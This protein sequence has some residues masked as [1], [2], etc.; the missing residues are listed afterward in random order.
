MKKIYLD[1]A[2]STP[3]SWRAFVAG[4]GYSL[5]HFGN[6]LSA[7]G[8]GKKAFKVIDQSRQ[9][10]AS[11]IK[12]NKSEI[13]FCGSGTESINLALIGSARANWGRGKHIITSA[14]EHH[15]VLNSLEYLESH[16]FEV[17]YLPVNELGL[18][19]LNDVKKFM[20]SDTILVSIMMAN[21]ETGAVQPIKEI[22]KIVKE[23]NVNCLVHTDAC[24]AGN[25]FDI[26]V[27]ELG[28]DLLSLDSSKVY[29]PKGVGALYVKNNTPIQPVIFGGTQENNLRAGTHNVGGVVSFA[30][31][32][33]ISQKRL[34]RDFK[35]TL[36]LKTW[37][38]D[39]LNK[40]PEVNLN[41]SIDNSLP[42]II[43][44]SI[45]GKSASQ[46][47]AWF[48]DRGVC[49][50]AGAAC[51]TGTLKP[52]HVV[53]AQTGRIDMA[54]SALRVSLG[55]STKLSDLKSLLNLIKIYVKI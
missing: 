2:A 7:H 46:G 6:P 50:S 20:R 30:Q 45:I 3:V 25:W 53:L 47:V 42:H 15:A 13:V 4:A 5:I 24:Q 10:L 28:V 12:A 39:E 19:D 1:Y 17:T 14:T 11:F 41:S 40:I 43:N 9:Q 29:G 26:N 51:T 23:I 21:N 27:Q 16:G 55:R 33:T 8:F 35:K 36:Q 31:A 44:F 34:A 48:N 52:S 38:I 37:F 22:V 54:Q 32:L 49:L 18:V